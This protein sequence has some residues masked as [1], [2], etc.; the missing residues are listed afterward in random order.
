MP[1]NPWG[2]GGGCVLGEAQ[3]FAFPNVPGVAEAAIL[4]TTLPKPHTSFSNSQNNLLCLTFSP[5]YG[6]EK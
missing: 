5:F 1:Q 4:G 3:E 2:G 6:G